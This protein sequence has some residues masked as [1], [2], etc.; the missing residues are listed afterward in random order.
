MRVATPTV[1]CVLAAVGV[2]AGR[3]QLERAHSIRPP[4]HLTQ[5]AVRILKTN[6]RPEWTGCHPNLMKVEP[7]CGIGPE[8]GLIGST[9]LVQLPGAALHL[10]GA[11]LRLPGAALRLPTPLRPWRLSMV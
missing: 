3:P 9:W 2:A 4:S 6:N 5:P 10:P 7:P 1:S 11:A 8:G